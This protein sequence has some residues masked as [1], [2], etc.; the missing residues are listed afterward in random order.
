[1]FLEDIIK[2]IQA[3]KEEY[4]EYRPH[5]SLGNLTPTELF[6]KVKKTQF[7][8]ARNKEGAQRPLLNN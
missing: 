8:V 2:K 1:L 7:I 4:N 5:S 6:K 3:Y